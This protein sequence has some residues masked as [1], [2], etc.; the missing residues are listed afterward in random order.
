MRPIARR[1]RW[2]VQA[3]FQLLDF[4]LQRQNNLDQFV[5]AQLL[6]CVSFVHTFT[7][8]PGPLARD[9]CFVH[10]LPAHFALLLAR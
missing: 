8:A 5:V 9:G 6:Q 7:L 3:V 1:F 2:A 10:C 4:R